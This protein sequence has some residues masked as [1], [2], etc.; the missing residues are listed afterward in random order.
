MGRE[1]RR[2]GRNGMEGLRGLDRI[3]GVWILRGRRCL[4]AVDGRGRYDWWGKRIKHAVR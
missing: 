3:E 4:D 1:Q 2:T